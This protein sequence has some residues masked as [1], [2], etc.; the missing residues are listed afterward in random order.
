LTTTSEAGAAAEVLEAR[1]ARLES[2]LQVAS[3][4]WSLALGFGEA[5]RVGGDRI[6]M[7]LDPGEAITAPYLALKGGALHLLGH[8][9]ADSAAALAAAVAEEERGKP[10]FVALWH[11]LEDARLENGMER[12][13]PGMARAF[14]ARFVPA[15]PGSLLRLAPLFQQVEIGLYWMGKGRSLEALKEAVVATL[16]GC[17]SWIAE[18][19][20][21]EGAEASLAAMRAIYPEVA[22]LLRGAP[23]RGP[24]RALE[25]S[26][27]EAGAGGQPP[28]PGPEHE[29]DPGAPEIELSDDLATVGVLGRRREMPEWYR[30]GSAPWF[31]RGLGE[32]KIHPSVRRP[33]EQTIVRADPGDLRAYLALWREVQRE[34]GRLEDRL[35]QLLREETYL[36]YGGQF[37]SGKLHTAKL[38]KQR[39]GVYRLFERPVRAGRSIA[40]SVLV[41]ESASMKGQEKFRLAAK[42]AILLGET[43]DHLDVPLEII[44]YTTAEYEARAAM[45]LGL[46]PAYEYRTM[47]CS[48]LQH[49]IYKTFNEPYRAVRARLSEIQPRH[50]NW[51]EESVIFASRRLRARREQSKVLLVISDGQPNGDAEH[52]VRAVAEAERSGCKVVG[53]GIGADFV[54]RIYRNAIVVEGFRPMGE[55]LLRLLARELRGGGQAAAG[56]RIGNG[57][58]AG[59]RASE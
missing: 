45:A 8:H 33:D 15:L 14:E 21:S 47:R 4:Q 51:D 39:L 31:E 6:A 20:Q 27:S 40:F 7:Q 12:R 35:I 43:L 56:S 23:R 52:L 25:E 38:W 22:G 29:G 24:R 26:A 32:K 49:R 3:R 30:P 59:W 18:A 2:L 50:N 44:G 37:R 58:L 46:T 53:L 19:A 34:V 42:T 57:P 28:R 5:D 55:E 16:R 36:R 48:A 9:L 17:A 54:R 13:W 41:D 11:A 10:H 1:R